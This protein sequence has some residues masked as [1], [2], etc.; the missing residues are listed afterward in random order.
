VEVRDKF[1]KRNSISLTVE[2]VYNKEVQ[3]L[4]FASGRKRTTSKDSSLYK[5]QAK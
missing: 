2:A 3:D 5:S 1:E 4:S